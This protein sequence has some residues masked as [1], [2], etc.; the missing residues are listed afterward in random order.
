MA[1]PKYGSA[2]QD[3]NG[4]AISG[5]QVTIID[6]ATGL[7]ATL[8]SD[9][10]GTTSTGN[11]LTTNVNGEFSFFAAVGSYRIQAEQS[12]T[13]LTATKDYVPLLDPVLDTIG[14]IACSATA[15]TNTLTVTSLS[16]IY[17]ALANGLTLRITLPSYT[18]TG[19]TSINYNGTTDLVKWIDGNDT[20]A[21]TG[22]TYGGIDSTYNKFIE[23]QFDGTDWL[24]VSD[25]AG[26]NTNGSWEKKSSGEQV[27]KYLESKTSIDVNSTSGSLYITTAQPKVT[28]PLGFSEIPVAWQHITI[29]DGSG[30]WLSSEAN[31]NTTTSQWGGYRIFDSASSTGNNLTVAHVARGR[32]Y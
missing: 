9:R 14:A 17:P 2:V 22:T 15:S 4:N 1:L 20:E 5:V 8:Y 27:C 10:A 21:A 23:V 28:F 6:T 32:W 11:P 25:V 29:T 12:G 19:Q 7:N 26:A 30:L 3:K 31:S 24:I 13:G 16:G 18:A